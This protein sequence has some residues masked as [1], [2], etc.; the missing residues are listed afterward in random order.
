MNFENPQTGLAMQHSVS[1][2]G[3]GRPF[4]LTKY[5]RGIFS[6]SDGPVFGWMLFQPGT[7]CQKERRVAP[8]APNPADRSSLKRVNLEDTRRT[9]PMPRKEALKRIRNEADR[10]V[11]KPA[12][13]KMFCEKNCN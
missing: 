11:P 13:R 8:T 3:P 10:A 4:L 9:H 6:P 5:R 7:H 1:S 2:Q 12:G